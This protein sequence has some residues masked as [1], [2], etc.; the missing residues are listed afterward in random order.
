M[1]KT[2]DNTERRFPF[3]GVGPVAAG[4]AA[5]QG[6]G[7][8]EERQLAFEPPDLLLGGNAR[9]FGRQNGVAGLRFGRVPLRRCALYD[10]APP[11]PNYFVSKT[12]KLSRVQESFFSY[13]R[14]LLREVVNGVAR[15]RLQATRCEI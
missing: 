9:R 10:L 4:R 3:A 12:V 7:R 5:D 6:E 14:S 8:A 2:I 11:R 1:R 13:C 15:K